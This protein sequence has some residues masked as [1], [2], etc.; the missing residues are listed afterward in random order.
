MKVSLNGGASSDA[1]ENLTQV[2]GVGGQYNFVAMAHEL[3]D[4]RS[5]LQLRSWRTRKDG[6]PESNIVFSYG[7][8]TIPR[9]LRDVVVTE[10]GIAD[11]RGKTDE[12]VAIALIKISDSRFQEE[13]LAQAKAAN[14]IRKG[15]HLPPR[16]S[17]NSPASYQDVLKELK[18]EELFPAFPLGCDFTPEELKVGKTLK[19]IKA[20]SSNKVS[21]IRFIWSSLWAGTC[22][23]RFL[24]LLERMK[25]ENPVGLKEKLYRKMLVKGFVTVL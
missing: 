6:I 17:N 18:K 9:H 21:M 14:K 5:V 1:L 4:A 20:L 15:Y 16:F 7:N 11:L 8:C 19:Y 12:E 10:Y 2:S 13:L 3:P 22:P 24:S 25:L 23:P